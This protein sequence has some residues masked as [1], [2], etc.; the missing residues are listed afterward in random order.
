MNRKKD[1]L[2]YWRAV[3]FQWKNEQ[4]RARQ[5]DNFDAPVWCEN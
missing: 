5:S 4:E 1:F 3:Y 2:N